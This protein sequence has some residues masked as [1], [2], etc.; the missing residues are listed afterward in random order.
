[1]D[2]QKQ[3]RPKLNQLRFLGQAQVQV[4]F[5]NRN[6]DLKS[7]KLGS[8]LNQPTKVQNPSRRKKKKK[9]SATTSQAVNQEKQLTAKPSLPQ[10]V[11]IRSAVMLQ[12]RPK[13][14]KLLLR[15]HHCLIFHLWVP[16][17]DLAAFL[18]ASAASAQ[19]ASA[20]RHLPLEAL[21]PLQALLAADLSVLSD[22]LRPFPSPSPTR[23]HKLTRSSPK[24]RM[25]VTTKAMTV[26]MAAKAERIMKRRCQLRRHASWRR[27][28]PAPARKTRLTFFR[29]PP[30]QNPPRIV[31]VRYE[32]APV[33]SPLYPDCFRFWSSKFVCILSSARRRLVVSPWPTSANQGVLLRPARAARLPFRF[34][35]QPSA[36][37]PPLAYPRRARLH[38]A[39]SV[40]F[41][42]L[43]LHLRPVQ[44][45]GRLAIIPRKHYISY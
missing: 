15:N 13:T 8:Q 21:L 4:T 12:P 25:K 27:L 34:R 40:P 24:R 17:A 10:A 30:V 35:R 28:R 16:P 14:R 43:S 19:A 20:A 38:V 6:L 1:M 3:K 42:A 5:D 31:Y 44:I 26:V 33:V 45:R 29:R 18:Q 9:R 39:K 37:F 22:R 11:K 36:N 23:R 2:Q 7:T 41:G 32:S